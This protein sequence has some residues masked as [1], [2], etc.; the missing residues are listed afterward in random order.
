MLHPLSHQS[1]KPISID[2]FGQNWQIT[3]AAQ[4]ALAIYG[5]NSFSA[6]KGMIVDL[7]SV[8]GVEDG[9][10]IINY[11]GVELQVTVQGE[12]VLVDDPYF[13]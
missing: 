3:T 7:A 13:R 5:V 4:S 2:V 6:F 8:R 9:T 10:Y 12:N 11:G 1:R